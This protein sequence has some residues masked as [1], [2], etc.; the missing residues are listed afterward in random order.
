M[1]EKVGIIYTRDPLHIENNQVI[2]SI[3]INVKSLSR[4]TKVDLSNICAMPTP[5]HQVQ[6]DAKN[7]IIMRKAKERKLAA[8]PNMVDCDLCGEQIEYVHDW[9]D[10]LCVSC[11]C[12]FNVCGEHLDGEMREN[13]QCSECRAGTDDEIEL[14]CHAMEK[15][16][17][18]SHN[19]AVA[20]GQEY[21]HSKSH[22]HAHGRE[23]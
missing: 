2:Q 11:E 21:H 23:E 1:P 4:I 3:S 12:W 15:L 10:A 20:T 9:T 13:Y 19:Y 16:K 18:H 14:L 8:L 17:V 22:S 6:I 7:N 5:F